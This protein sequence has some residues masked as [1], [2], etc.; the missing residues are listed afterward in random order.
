MTGCQDGVY[1]RR[2][3]L[4]V[5]TPWIPY[6]ITGADQQ[7]RFYGFKQFQRLGY[8][9][10][11]IAKIHA[12]QPEAEI[13]A[14][15]EKEGI[16]VILVPYAP[17]LVRL[18]LWNMFRVLREPALLDGAA[19]EYLD[20]ATKRAVTECVREW[21]PDAAWVEFSF[22][23]PMNILLRRLGVPVVMRSANNEAQQAID[24]H[25][26][27]LPHRI[28]AVPK[29]R[30]ERLAAR[31]CGV[32]LAIT[33]WE[34]SWYERCGAAD[35]D[36]LPL[37][38]LHRTI[39]RRIHI[40]KPVLD[41]VFL[42]SSYT[43]GHNRDA[44][45]FIL[46]E[47]LPLLRERMPGTYKLHVTGKKFPES[48][49]GYLGPDVEVHGFIPA[50]DAFLDSMDIA[51]CPSVSGQGMQQKVYEPLCCGL[52]LVTHH[53]AGY[54]FEDGVHA[55]YAS[56]P[57]GFADAVERLRD[58]ATR[59]RL[60]DAALRVAETCFSTEAIDRVTSGALERA[61]SRAV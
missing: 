55:L 14:L 6:P 20:T 21:K 38:G 9:V 58:V 13:R 49:N 42:G 59:Q 7:D 19:L 31:T 35:V 56:A 53:T 23:W 5:V 17:S 52:P 36:V 33:P 61:M 41:L 48:F 28:L 43:N 44:L 16:D 11:V 4:L 15:Y 60:A 10:R 22:L 57:E 34:K 39:R 37:R 30:G 24:E 2:M 18:L 3:R 29:F 46:T 27:S 47:V 32:M 1:A 8:D 50:L 25:R 54:P 51:L 40:E 26:G 45:E 12:F